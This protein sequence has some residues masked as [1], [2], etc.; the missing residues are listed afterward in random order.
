MIFDSAKQAGAPV[1]PELVLLPAISRS[2]KTGPAAGC[3]LDLQSQGSLLAL[4]KSHLE[5]S[6]GISNDA[7]RRPRWGGT[8]FP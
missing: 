4:I 2:C 3:Q 8:T 7:E 6:T 1:S 5:T